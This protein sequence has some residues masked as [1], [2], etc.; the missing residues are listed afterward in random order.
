M[1][2]IRITRPTIYDLPTDLPLEEY[3]ARILTPR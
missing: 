3:K 1:E 2:T